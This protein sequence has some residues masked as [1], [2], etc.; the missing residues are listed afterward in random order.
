VVLWKTGKLPDAVKWMRKARE[1]LPDNVRVLFNAVQILISHMQQRGYEPELEL[2]ARQVLEHV[3]RLQPGQQRFA[4][5]MEQLGALQPKPEPQPASAEPAQE[6][7]AA[8][9]KA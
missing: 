2:E 8:A 4:Q 7:E 9:P 1:R 3:D 5:L 6:E